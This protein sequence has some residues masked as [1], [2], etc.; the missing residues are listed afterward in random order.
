MLCVVIQIF[1]IIYSRDLIG[2]TRENVDSI[3]ERFEYK[4]KSDE[5]LA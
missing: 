4:L 5:N 2:L 3:H 1:S